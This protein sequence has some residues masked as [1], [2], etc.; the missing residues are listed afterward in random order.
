MSAVRLPP[1]CASIVGP[2][3]LLLV[4]L[5]ESRNRLGAS[6][7]AQ[8]YGAQGGAPAD[9]QNPDLLRRFAAALG[10]LRA[11]ALVLA[12]HDRARMVDSR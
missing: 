8:V 10:A 7:L 1:Y 4:D 12:Y 9:M 11:A 3:S 5:G 2:T 6:A